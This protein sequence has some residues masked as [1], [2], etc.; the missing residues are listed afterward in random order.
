MAVRQLTTKDFD[1][2]DATGYATTA[3]TVVKTGDKL[4][5]PK[6]I[7]TE[8]IS[9]K[10]CGGTIYHNPRQWL[11]NITVN[12]P[13]VLTTE[14]E[15]NYSYEYA[16]QIIAAKDLQGWEHIDTC[17]GCL[18]TLGNIKSDNFAWRV[19]ETLDEYILTDNED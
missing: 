13:L 17:Y 2:L 4:G 6:D 3:S 18:V 16:Q 14:Q 1:M 15:I 19:Q 11:Q 7:L 10:V 9:C 12:Q 5:P 8:M